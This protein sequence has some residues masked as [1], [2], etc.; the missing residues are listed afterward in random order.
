MASPAGRGAQQKWVMTTAFQ[1]CRLTLFNPGMQFSC[2]IAFRGQSLQVGGPEQP[3]LQAA[4]CP[5]FQSGQIQSQD[6][7][8]PPRRTIRLERSSARWI[9]FKMK[10]MIEIEYKRNFSHLQS[11]DCGKRRSNGKPRRLIRFDPGGTAPG[12]F[13]G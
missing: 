11:P 3:A 7:L 4:P 9:F 8:D 13:E 5:L 6:E 2:S 1:F 10:N 12:G